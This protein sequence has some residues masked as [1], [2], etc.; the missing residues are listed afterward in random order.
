MSHRH[1]LV[2]NSVP[3]PLLLPSP[4]FKIQCVCLTTAEYLPVTAAVS[5]KVS[6]KPQHNNRERVGRR[7]NGRRDQMEKLKFDLKTARNY[8]LNSKKQQQKGNE[9]SRV[10]T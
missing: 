10:D 6:P 3:P 9:R 2:C 1:P 5:S 8:T 4:Q 7:G